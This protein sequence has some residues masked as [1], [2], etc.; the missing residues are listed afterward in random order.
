MTPERY[1][2]IVGLFETVVEKGLAERSAFLAQACAGDE[3]LRR[4]VEAMLD[5]DR[6]PGGM[7]EKPPNDLAAERW[8]QVQSLYHSVLERAP[9]ERS[10]FLA[11]ACEGNEELRR[12]VESLLAS[13]DAAPPRETIA[14]GTEFGVYRIEAVLGEGGMGV[15][16]RALDT[17]LNRPVAIKFL[18]AR[19]A[20]ESARRRFQ[21]EAKT[22]SSLNHPHIVTVHEAGEFE[23][24]QYLVTEFVDGGTLKDWAQSRVKRTWREVVE[25][26]VGVADGLACAHAAGILHRDIK[27]TNILVGKNGYAKL[28]DFG[29]AKLARPTESDAVNRRPAET[30]TRTGMILGTIPYMSP[31]QT[32]GRPLNARSD[33]FSFGIVLHEMLAG[34][35]PFEGSTDLEILQ[36]IL[37]RAPEP[38]GREIPAA[39]RVAVEKALEKDPADRYPSMRDLVVDLRRLGRLNGE[40]ARTSSR[41]RWAWALLPLVLLIAGLFGWQ[42]WQRPE[43]QEVLQA[44]PLTTLRGVQRSPSFSPDGNRVAFSWTGPKQDNPDIY[45]QQIGAGIP[46]RLTTDPANDYNPVWSP[47]DRWIAFLRGQPETGQIELRLIPPLGGPERKLAEIRVRN[48]FYVIPPYLTWCPDSTCLVVTHSPGEGQ[49]EALFVISL[50]SGEK[51]QLTHP[52]AGVGDS[53]P[54]VSPDG[55]SLVFRRNPNALFTGALYELALGRGLTPIGEPRRLTLPVL[56]AAYPTW[57]PGSKEIL[58]SRPLSGILRRMVVTGENS[59]E[60]LPSVGVDG[61][62][63]V[64]SPR[65]PSRLSR[66]VYVHSSQDV[67][68]WRIDTSAPGA[69][70]SSPAAVAIASTRQEGMPQL[71]PDGRRVAFWSDR[72][73][74]SEIWLADLDGA[75]PIQ[76]TSMGAGVRGYPHWS[77]DGRFIVFH[78]AFEGQWEVFEIPASGGR[79][80]NLTSNPA[81]DYLPSF[82]AD[83]KWIYFNSSRSGEFR[84]WK[85]PASGGDPVQVKDAVGFA[86]Q[87]SPDGAYLYYVQTF[88]APSALWRVPVSGGAPVKMVESVLLANFVVLQGGIYYIDR[89][90]SQGDVHYFDLPSGKTRLQYFD[91]ATRKSRTVV[92]D[93][94]VVD[95]PL[96]ATADG[97]TIL[98]PRIDS[99]VD[100]MMLVENFR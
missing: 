87:E 45:I 48:G 73:G 81:N 1:R 98:F 37:H 74:E 33:I 64:V 49:S 21:Q 12:E 76:L 71:S 26:L 10:A 35:R 72:S 60:R 25:L 29:L 30:G 51:K 22:A 92:P 85:M 90:S 32:A 59:P 16:Y 54:A 84:I 9:S 31:E 13:E 15:V 7:L 63:P 2:Q 18:S 17:R 58:F 20:D 52:P 61:I 79:A 28:A 4:E 42:V 57:M 43:H 75:N 97:R 56:D 39:L 62:M 66:L 36:T 19:V 50:E 86:P 94:G 3:A 38:L 96:T 77:P 27:P 99:S 34:R 46:L 53:N 88:D 14:P 47:D 83:G 82:S 65:L 55:R 11:Q 24:L 40:A 89:S 70:A 68:I 100:D 6:L 44:L 5:A 80:R 95:I 91:F 41:R 8:R 23:G 93:L 67:N 69:P 78:S